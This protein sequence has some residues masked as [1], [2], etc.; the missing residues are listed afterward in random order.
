M[1]FAV[2]PHE[3]QVDSIFRGTGASLHEWLAEFAVVSV[4]DST[5]SAVHP[6]DVDS[7]CYAAF[8]QHA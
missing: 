8:D 2:L 5:P 3:P 1:V 7:G 4:T 6:P